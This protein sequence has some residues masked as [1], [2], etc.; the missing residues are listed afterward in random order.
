MNLRDLREL[1]SAI[2]NNNLK[3]IQQLIDSDVELVEGL[4]PQGERPLESAIESENITIIKELLEAGAHPDYG[5]WTSPL[6]A[7][8][9]TGNPQIVKLLLEAGA[10]PNLIVAGNLP[11]T[12][13]AFDGYLDIVK[14]LVNEGADVNLF[15]NN[16]GTTLEVAVLNGHYEIFNYLAPLTSTNLKNRSETSSL[17]SSVRNGNTKAINFLVESGI[18]INQFYEDEDK[19]T[20][21]MYA[22]RENQLSSVEVLLKWKA[23]VN[24]QNSRGQTALML[25]SQFK[26][27]EESRD[28]DAPKIIKIKIKIIKLLIKANANVNT[29]DNNRSTAL[30]LAKEIGNTEVIQLLIEAGAKED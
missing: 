15:D 11:L 28:S 7:A 17:F 23:D 3:K 9:R 5:G 18:N 1:L 25:A 13:A 30:S 19:D 14:I 29:Q 24:I 20:C 6:D 12:T 2:E 27:R 21:L 4:T 26:S 10:E 22:V 16:T 8:V